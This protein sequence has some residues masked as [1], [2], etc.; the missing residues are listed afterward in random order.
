[1]ITNIKR[2][3]N[4]CLAACLITSLCGCRPLQVNNLSDRITPSNQRSWS[5]ELAVLPSAVFQ[6][7]QIQIKNIRNTNYLSDNDFVVKHYDRTI[8]INDV[9]SVDFIVT[10]FNSFAALAHTMLSFGLSDGTYIGLSVEIRNENGEEYSPLLGIGN[11]FEVTYVI[12]DERDLIRVRTHHRDSNVYVFP[13]VATP[14]QA[15]A[16]FADVLL[17]VNELN[18]KPEFYNTFYNNCT[19]NLVD[20]VNQLKND[21]VPFNVRV[22][23]PGFSAK[24]AYEIGLLDNQV[25]FEDLQQLALVNDLVEQHYNDPNFSQLIRNQRSRIE[26][27]VNRQAARDPALNSR[28]KDYLQQNLPS[29]TT[30]R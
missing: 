25:P 10:P 11:Q 24:Y 22:L 18:A 19:T 29:G 3:T 4:I 12:A 20:H 5:P 30:W 17:R 26:R 13:S 23:L 14:Q 8:N 15:Q 7:D 27:L 16:L 21:R 1:M 9:Q 28:G 2:I 6:G